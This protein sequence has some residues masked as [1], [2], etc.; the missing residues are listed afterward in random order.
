MFVFG[1]AVLSVCPVI[2]PFG[3][4]Y[5]VTLRGYLNNIGYFLGYCTIGWSGLWAVHVGWYLRFLHLLRKFHHQDKSTKVDKDIHIKEVD[6]N[7]TKLNINKKYNRNEKSYNTRNEKEMLRN[8]INNNILLNSSDSVY[9]VARFLQS[10][11]YILASFCKR[12]SV[13]LPTLFATLLLSNQARD[14]L[15][16]I[17]SVSFKVLKTFAI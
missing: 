3:D 7:D 10:V 8:K 9:F 14:F 12:A 16:E 13:W 1:S 6:V 4:P 15:Y 2:C 17:D 5:D 11:V